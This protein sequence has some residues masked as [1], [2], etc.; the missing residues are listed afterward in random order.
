MPYGDLG[1]FVRLSGEGRRRRFARIRLVAGLADVGSVFDAVDVEDVVF[2]VEG[3]QRAIVAAPC[4]GRA[5]VG[6][7]VLDIKTD[8]LGCEARD[9]VLQW[10]AVG[11]AVK[12]LG[13]KHN[14]PGPE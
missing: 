12:G 11:Q 6:A 14:R 3:E 7:W 10:R 8:A 4:A 5:S 1:F 2:N 9:N 13:D